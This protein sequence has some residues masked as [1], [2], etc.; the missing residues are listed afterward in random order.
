MVVA[1]HAGEKIAASSSSY[2]RGFLSRELV[3]GGQVARG[4]SP[5]PYLSPPLYFLSPL[6]LFLGLSMAVHGWSGDDTNGQVPCIGEPLLLPLA[7]PYFLLR[8]GQH[9][10]G[11]GYDA[12][13][14]Y[15]QRP[16]GESPSSSLR[17]G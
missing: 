14:T 7:N 4:G 6:Y 15:Q 3:P 9:K 2:A 16:F 5:H 17:L 11:A 1:K 10:S 8:W 13:K 12:S